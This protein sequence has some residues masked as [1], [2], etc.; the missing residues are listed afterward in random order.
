MVNSILDPCGSS[1][2]LKHCWHPTGVQLYTNPPIIM[3]VCCHCGVERGERQS[4]GPNLGCHG[5]H[6]PDN[7]DKEPDPPVPDFPLI[8]EAADLA[9]ELADTK[10]LLAGKH[11]TMYWPICEGKAEKCSHCNG[12]GVEPI[13]DEDLGGGGV[14][15]SFCRT[16]GGAGV[17]HMGEKD[18]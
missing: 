13:V 6:H 18:E 12:T 7:P 8:E 10:P 2:N 9:K 15:N 1:D 17:Q 16:C 4:L 11:H 5:P 14:T 3:K